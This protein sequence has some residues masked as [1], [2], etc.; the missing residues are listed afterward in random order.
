[1]HKEKL[2]MEEEKK[3]FVIKDKRIFDESGQTREAGEGPKVVTEEKKAAEAP[4]FEPEPEQGE[5][6]YLPEINFPSFIISLST[7]ALFHFG[8]FPDPETKQADKNLTAAKQIIDTLSMLK[9]K[10][11]GNLDENEQNLIDGALYE[12]RMR[13]VKE[14]G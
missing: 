11:E 12:L 6:G 7:T 9:E 13:Y 8:D 2:V 3:G 1:M 4:S 5:D 14:K 10:T